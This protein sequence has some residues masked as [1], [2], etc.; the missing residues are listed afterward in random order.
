VT[1]LGVAGAPLLVDSLGTWVAEMLDRCGG[2]D[3]VPGWGERFGAEVAALVTAWRNTPRRVVAVGEETG[4]GVVP[5][6]ASGRRFRDA[7]GL[8]TQRLAAESERV[9][10]VTAG[11][12]VPLDQEVPGG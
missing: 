8:L 2:W 12:V 5:E 9:L 3:D 4:W 7:L 11:R 1:A 10:L 6:S